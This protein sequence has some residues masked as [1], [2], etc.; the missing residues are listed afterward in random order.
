MVM[1][2]VAG[3]DKQQ[4][5]APASGTIILDGRPLVGASITTQPIAKGSRNPGAGSF[6]RTDDRGHFDLELVK[7]AV[8][9]AIIGDHRVMISPAGPDSPRSEPK[10]SA[11]GKS[12]YWTDNPRSNRE[13]AEKDWP[14]RFTDGSLSITVPQGGTDQLRLDLT[15]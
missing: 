7:P 3:C 15:R 2:V 6:G 5:I 12:R 14:A 8:K 10:Q 11:D 13:S 1:L 4:P 9:G